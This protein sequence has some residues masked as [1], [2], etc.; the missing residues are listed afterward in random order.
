MPFAVFI[1]YGPVRLRFFFRFH[2]RTSKHYGRAK[3]IN[4]VSNISIVIIEE[5]YEIS[6]N[7]EV[8]QT[9]EG[10]KGEW[11]GTGW[12]LDNPAHVELIVTSNCQKKVDQNLQYMVKSDLHPVPIL[13]C[14]NT[15]RGENEAAQRHEGYGGS[16]AL[17]IAGCG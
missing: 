8:L 4:V 3:S 6:T 13:R 10:R 11:Y 17:M 9:H 14:L 2:N 7:S 12:R 16:R 5:E 15:W 1:G